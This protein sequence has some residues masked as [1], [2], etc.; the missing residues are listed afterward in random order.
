MNKIDQLCRIISHPRELRMALS[1]LGM[2]LS[3][4]VAMGG[5]TQ[6][7]TDFV[8]SHVADDSIFVEI[9]TLFG[10]TAKA[11]ASRTAARVIAVDNFSWN[12]FGLTPAQHEAFTRRILEGTR[13]ELV[14]ADA[15][16]YIA[17]M[18]TAKG[19]WM[20]FLDGD[21]RYEAVKRELE[22][23]KAKGVRKLSGHDF[24]NPNFGVTKAVREIVGEPKST[25]GM[26]WFNVI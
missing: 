17:T 4:D 11:V 15:L 1:G 5:L 7:E 6:V 12:P 9:G 2:R 14:N 10:L 19:D 25:A 16:D 8:V 23:L 21:H 18:D 20:V 24:G 22:L 3:G 26:C 13:V